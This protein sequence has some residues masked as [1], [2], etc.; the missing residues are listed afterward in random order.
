M[1]HESLKTIIKV[2]INFIN[3]ITNSNQFSYHSILILGNSTKIL[4]IRTN[5]M[6]LND[7]EIKKIVFTQHYY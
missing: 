1:G 4:E 7:G 5:N 6:P 2:D 3:N